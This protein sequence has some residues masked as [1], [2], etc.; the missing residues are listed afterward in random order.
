MIE[1]AEDCAV[2]ND[3]PLIPGKCMKLK[4]AVLVAL[5]GVH[6]ALIFILPDEF[7]G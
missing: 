2:S 7:R 4:D 3:A 5:L 1:V 6:P